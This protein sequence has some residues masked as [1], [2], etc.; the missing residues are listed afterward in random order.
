MFERQS[1]EAFPLR[2]I[3][4]LALVV[5]GFFAFIYSLQKNRQAPAQGGLKPSEQ[6]Y[7][8]RD[9]PDFRPDA[10]MYSLA[11]HQAHDAVQQRGPQNGISAPW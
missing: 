8:M 3:L 9:Y 10:A 11:L 2:N 5:L 6:F 7:A 4:I 1:R